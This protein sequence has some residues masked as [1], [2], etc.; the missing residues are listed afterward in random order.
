[1]SPDPN[2]FTSKEFI[3][4]VSTEG[5]YSLVHSCWGVLGYVKGDWCFPKLCHF[6]F[7]SE[8]STLV[9]SDFEQVNTFRAITAI[10]IDDPLIRLEGDSL[11][12]NFITGGLMLWSNLVTLVESSD[13]PA[14]GTVIVEV[15]SNDSWDYSR[16]KI[17]FDPLQVIEIIIRIH[18]NENIGSLHKGLNCLVSPL[19]I[20]SCS[21]WGRFAK[22]WIVQGSVDITDIKVV[23]I[24]CSKIF[25]K[26]S[27]VFKLSTESYNYLLALVWNTKFKFFWS[28]ST[29]SVSS[30]LVGSYWEG[31]NWITVKLATNVNDPL[32]TLE[33]DSLGVPLHYIST[34]SLMIW[35]KLVTIVDGSD[36][37]KAVVFPVE[38]NSNDSWNGSLTKNIDGPLKVIKVAFILL[39]WS[40]HGWFDH[41]GSP[42]VNWT[43]WIGSG[44]RVG[45]S[46][47]V[48]VGVRVGV[49]A[50]AVLFLNL[51]VAFIKLI[52]FL[53]IKV[54]II[55]SRGCTIAAIRR[56]GVDRGVA[57]IIDNKNTGCWSC[58][59][60][61]N[62]SNQCNVENAAK[63][64]AGNTA[65][66][67]VSG[68]LDPLIDF[69][70]L[71]QFCRLL[72]VLP[73][74]LGDIWVGVWACHLAHIFS[75]R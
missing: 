27:I 18:S 63:S 47:S 54:I 43:I 20:H 30:S 67:Y 57:R 53:L 68:T 16:T 12:L 19:F 36:S 75:W 33:Y 44:F 26:P 22:E 11:S 69:L 52:F 35:S 4:K 60:H 3:L 29:I 34:F 39:V 42:S 41:I 40:L 15:K 58:I 21:G 6:I 46:V 38:I 72:F 17:V 71:L 74:V 65:E 32:I 55:S 7:I 2:Q 70:S 66:D 49:C 5:N 50:C 13:S 48:S 61:K 24:D 14:A 9:G 56:G 51:R 73:L 8:A 64:K 45:I 37:L 59:C 10:D 25:T 62:T 28:V 1:M 31:F 23:S